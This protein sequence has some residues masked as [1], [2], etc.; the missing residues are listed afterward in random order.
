VGGIVSGIFGGGGGSSAP[1]YTAPAPYQPTGSAD[2]DKTW[3]AALAS[4]QGSNPYPSLIPQ[5]N[6]YADQ[7]INNPYAAGAQTAANTAGGTAG[8]V[9]NALASLSALFGGE[10]NSLSPYMSQ[11][12]NQGFDPQNAL[13]AQTLQKVNDQANVA[14]AQYGLTGQQAAGN[15]QQAD[16]NFNIDWQSQQLARALQGISGASGIAGTQTG[17]GSAAGSTGT[18]ATSL[19]GEAGSLPYSTY[20]GNIGNIL[21]TLT[22]KGNFGAQNSAQ[23]QELMSQV[24]PYLYAGQGAV[25]TAANAAGVNAQNTQLAGQ[26]LGQ[27]FSGLSGI[28]NLFGGG[29][30]AASAATD[31]SLPGGMSTFSDYSALPSLAGDSGFFSGAGDFLASAGSSLMDFLPAIF[32]L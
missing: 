13:Y 17:L 27:I 20:S 9:G 1:H 32:A 24:I 30:G 22:G 3:Q 26:G 29:G 31:F 16:T 6:S 15:L 4:L 14:N 11:I 10:A 12:L 18:A 8:N 5:Y 2:A 19:Q 7:N 28:G 25:N 21:Q 23:I